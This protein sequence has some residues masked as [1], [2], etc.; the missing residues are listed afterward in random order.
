[1]P[2][3]LDIGLLRAFATVA[4]RRRI[5]A[6]ANTLNLTQGAVS[7]QIARFEALCGATLFER[8]PRGLRL[9]AAG[10]RLLPNIRKLLALNDEIWSDMCGEAVEGSI[11]VGAPQDLIGAWVAPVFRA[12]AEAF[13]QIEVSLVCESSPTLAG[14]LR[15][16]DLDLALIEEPLGASGAEVLM[17]DPVVWIGARSGVAHAKTPLPVSLI[18]DTC[19]FRPAISSALKSHGRAWRGLFETGNLESTLGIVRN[20]LAVGASL[21][22]TVPDDLAILGPESGLPQLPAFAITLQTPVSPA[23]PAVSELAGFFRSAFASARSA[24]SAPLPAPAA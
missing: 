11:R 22:M 14:R 24:E 8:D 15:A 21:A 2:R 4:D 10:Q 6:A 3:N 19:A 20:D 13:P 17:V 16:G 5:T 23:P 18:C 1:M 12:F 9:T 7:Q